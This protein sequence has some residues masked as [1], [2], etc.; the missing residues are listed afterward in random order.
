MKRALKRAPLFCKR[1]EK[2]SGIRERERHF[3]ERAISSFV[4]LNSLN[5]ENKKLSSKGVKSFFDDL[6]PNPLSRNYKKID[7][8]K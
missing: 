2:A 1:K 6:E 4:S 8:S 5:I 7:T 3:E